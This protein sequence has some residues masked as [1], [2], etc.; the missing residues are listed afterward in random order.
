MTIPADV[1]LNSSTPVTATIEADNVRLAKGKSVIVKLTDA[2]NTE[3]GN[4]FHVVTADNNSMATYQINNG[5]TEIGSE[6]AEFLTY[7]GKQYWDMD[8]SAA[9]GDTVAENHSETLTFTM[10]VEA[11]DKKPFTLGGR[12]ISEHST[13]KVVNKS[14]A[15][16]I[17]TAEFEYVG[18][19]FEQTFYS[20]I[21]KSNVDKSSE[22]SYN[23]VATVDGDN[24]LV[25]FIGKTNSKYNISGTFNTTD[26]SYNIVK[27]AL[28]GSIT[29]VELNGKEILPRLSKVKTVDV[30]GVSL[31]I[32]AGDTW[33]QIAARN[34]DKI[35]L[36]DNG[37][38]I[39]V[40]KNRASEEEK[41]MLLT[42]N[43]DIVTAGT[44]Y[45]EAGNVF[46][47]TES[48]PEGAIAVTGISLS[49]TTGITLNVGGTNTLI[50]TVLPYNATDK[51]I[52]W[53]S[54]NTD[55]ATVDENGKVTAVAAGD[56]T[57]TATAGGQSASCAV[58]VNAG[59]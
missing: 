37:T 49:G 1:K 57:I 12:E 6:V 51:T 55:V 3:S 38:A 15:D 10:S 27:G 33:E 45:S 44:V 8:F 31:Q 25:S 4:K 34:P 50:A 22:K 5:Y 23:V 14:G 54:S 32:A 56:A 48:N 58:K 2:S 21:N 40:M 13:L 52:T 41:E 29:S 35:F 11:R 20:H 24:I 39:L 9:S 18:G 19:K 28:G 43:D 7:S 17:I 36:M 16:S 46:K 59:T 47:W 30:D 26:N 42:N 53:T